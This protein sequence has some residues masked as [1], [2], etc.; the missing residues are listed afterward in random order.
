MVN[1]AISPT[2]WAAIPG[3]SPLEA[4]FMQDMV[5]DMDP[6]NLII[7]SLEVKGGFLNTPH[8][9]LSANLEH[10]RLPFQGFLQAYLATCLYKMQTDVGTTPRT[11]P[12]SGVPQKGAEGPFLFLLVTLPLAFYIRRTYP[13]VA[14]Y[15]IWTTLLVFADDMA[16]VIATARKPL[17]DARDNTRANQVLHNVTSYLENNRLLVHNVKSATMVHN[18]P[19]PPLQPGDPFMTPMG[20]TNYLAIQQEA[21]L[22]KVTLP[23]NL[24]HRLPRNLVTARIAALST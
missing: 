22:E 2:T 18:A 14:P 15:P 21:T 4:I 3:H 16:V 9:L 6:I 8:R 1:R 13:D 12:T 10:M 5:V 7:T 11:Q 17:P 24:E 23:A 20:T 19:H